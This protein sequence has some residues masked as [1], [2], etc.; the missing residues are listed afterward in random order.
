MVKYYKTTKLSAFPPNPKYKSHN[1]EYLSFILRG[2]FLIYYPSPLYSSLSRLIIGSIFYQ[3][4][5]IQI[6]LK[7]NITS[8][9]NYCP[10]LEED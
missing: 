10:F 7:T 9:L 5:Y 1:S 3:Y 6:Q 4:F 8:L 2:G